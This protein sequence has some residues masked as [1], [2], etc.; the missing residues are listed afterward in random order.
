[1][2]LTSLK[3]LVSSLGEFAT[4]Q[5]Y[6]YL[7]LMMGLPLIDGVFLSIVLT[8]GLSSVLDSI[9]VGSFVLGG[10]ATTGIILSE[11]TDRSSKAIKK[12]LLIAIVIGF[13][14]MIQASFAPMIEPLIDTQTFKYGAVLA[15]ISLSLRIIP[16]EKTDKIVSP[17][18]VIFI[19]IVLSVDPSGLSNVGSLSYSLSNGFYALLSVVVAFVISSIAILARPILRGRVSSSGLKYATATGLFAVTLSII[20]IVPSITAP[21]AFS[22][23]ALISNFNI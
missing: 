11:F 13:I 23:T 15:L 10:G 14:A 1:M 8:D 5:E 4:E 17:T 3:T 9:M 6:Q 20:G 22:F 2:R 19:A 21:V 18:T 12:T 7:F 16:H